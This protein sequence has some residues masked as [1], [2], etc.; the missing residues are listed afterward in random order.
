M[1]PVVKPLEPAIEQNIRASFKEAL[2]LLKS[3]ETVKAAQI[4]LEGWDRMPE[5]RFGWDV[6]LSKTRVLVHILRE[7]GQYESAI[8]VLRQHLQSKFYQEYQYHPYFLL[9][10]VYFVMGDMNAARENFKIADEISGGRCFRD[11]NPEFEKLIQI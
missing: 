10:T 11:E 2:V 6:S 7:A 1:Q 4:A 3:G 5:P 9:G 8:A